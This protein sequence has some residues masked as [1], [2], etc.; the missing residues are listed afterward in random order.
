MWCS[1]W[2]ARRER[3]Q[4]GFP[5]RDGLGKGDAGFRHGEPRA[6]LGDLALS[7]GPRGLGPE[8]REAGLC[9]SN[10]QRWGCVVPALPAVHPTLQ[11]SGA[12]GHVRNPAAAPC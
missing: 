12:M 7:S 2:W 5:H 6:P 9:T 3:P 10:Q 11:D 1:G 8:P 4:L